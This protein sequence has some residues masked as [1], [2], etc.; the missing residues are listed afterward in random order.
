MNSHSQ[1]RLDSWD[2][3]QII[4]QIIL[5]ILVVLSGCKSAETDSQRY[6][7]EKDREVL[8]KGLEDSR[9][10]LHKM[11]KGL[12]SDQWF[13]K[14]DSAVWSIAD[15]I[16]HLGLQEDMHYRELYILSL[17]PSQK[18]HIGKTRINDSKVS[19]YEFNPE[20]DKSDWFVE[21]LGRWADKESAIYQ[22]NRSR[23]KMIE[24]VE[25]TDAD[26]RVHF[27][28]RDIEDESDFR[29]VRDLHQIVLTTVAHTRRHIHQIERIK[30]QP[31][32]PDMRNP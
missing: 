8:L 17:S 23:D 22:F 3:R 5:T 21:P 6:W 28:F 12:S 18:D 15:I 16:E 9:N 11:V 13:F 29:R 32:F 20:K 14:S 27:T 24:F 4:Y 2:Q 1:N 7:T 31:D 19:E 25:L 26:L 10:Q 30:D